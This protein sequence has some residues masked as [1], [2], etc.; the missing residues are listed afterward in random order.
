MK[1]S[2]TRKEPPPRP[3]AAPQIS[4]QHNN[5]EETSQ[6]TLRNRA[7]VMAQPQPS[8]DRTNV[9]GSTGDSRSDLL[10]EIRRG[11][12][13]KPASERELPSVQRSNSGAGADALA[14]ALRRAL[15]E[16]GRV[17]RSSDEES[18]NSTDN[19]N[20]WDD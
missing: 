8:V 4:H 3:N 19:D 18:N 15:M 1:R 16:R 5:V 17:I 14:D 7:P 10:E 13:L 2:S 6:V 12:D 11:R 9:V 20:E